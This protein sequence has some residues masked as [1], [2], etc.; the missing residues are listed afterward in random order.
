[1][2]L[3]VW[4]RDIG[5]Y[6]FIDHIVDWG[7]RMRITKRA[8]T[9][10]AIWMIGLGV[11]M[12]VVFPFFVLLFDVSKD[13]ALSWYFIVSC[14]AAG[15]IV[16]T[17]NIVISRMVVVNRIRILT[18][19]MSTVKENLTRVATGEDIE[20]CDFN[21]CHIQVDSEDE[22]GNNIETYNHLVDT[23]SLTMKSELLTSQLDLESLGD[24]AA[25][26]LMETTESMACAILL[27][28]EG[29]LKI[30]KSHGV[31]AP[32]TLLNNDTVLEVARLQKRM[33]VEVPDG[34][35][36][37]GLLATFKPRE[38]IV[39]PL[40]FK[41]ISLGVAMIASNRPFDPMVMLNLSIFS[42]SLGLALHNAF[43]HEQTQ[44]LAALDPLSGILNRRFGMVRMREEFSRAVRTHNALGVIMLDIDHFKK[45]NDMYGHLAGDKVIVKI[46]RVV[47]SLLREGDVF[48]RYGG[49]EFCVALP[50]ASS[51]DAYR[52]AEKLRHAVSEIAVQYKDITVS[53]T[54]SLGVTAFPEID[55]DN[56]Q[57]MIRYADDA[58]YQ[59]KE[60]GR[61][62]T[63]VKC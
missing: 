7:N 16:G 18:Q 52:I 10:L 19:K 55:V 36:L 31:H 17:V 47:R 22:L 34:V 12:G 38:I 33:K 27:E 13:I 37:D 59:S 42:K 24:K 28:T 51:E 50:G 40:R 29:E 63:T 20:V 32:E 62:Q 4:K 41:E 30:L 43:V 2:D 45:V 57:D 60:N 5:V 11:L 21:S 35:Q 48:L 56:E 49:E 54:I 23:L 26:L 8:F 3:D 58:L 25:T 53:V 1:M 46:A 9:D 6:V 15:T 39:E 61:N 44:K 14:I